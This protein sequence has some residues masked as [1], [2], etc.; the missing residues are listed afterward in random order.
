MNE[1]YDDRFV[2][3]ILDTFSDKHS[4]VTTKF[5]FLAETFPK[6]FSVVVVVALHIVVAAFPCSCTLCSYD[7][8]IIY[9][10][11]QQTSS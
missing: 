4:Q 9:L 11:A 6:S 3:K 8:D 2:V 1:Y 10:S 5:R 7:T